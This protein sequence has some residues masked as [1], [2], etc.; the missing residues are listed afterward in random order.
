MTNESNKTEG[1]N[2]KIVKPSK[3]GFAGMTPEKRKEI[4]TKGGKSVPKEKRAY[5]VNRDLASKSGVK[6]GKAVRASKRAFSMDPEL[7]SR[8]GKI[9]GAK[10]GRWK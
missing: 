5:S 3:R 2:W 4:A 8:A 7:A 6:G 10:G 9:G 1:T